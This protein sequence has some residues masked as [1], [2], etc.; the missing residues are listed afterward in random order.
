MKTIVQQKT[1]ERQMSKGTQFRTKKKKT[2]QKKK[3]KGTLQ[4]KH[5]K[6]KKQKI[7]NKT[8][9]INRDILVLYLQSPIPS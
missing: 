6:K 3:E 2:K 9:K 4:H 5:G 1:K 7:I 8:K